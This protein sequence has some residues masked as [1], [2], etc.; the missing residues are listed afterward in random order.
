MFLNI[1]EFQFHEK[2]LLFK[3]KTWDVKYIKELFLIRIGF[4]FF[5]KH[6]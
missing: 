5:Q 3:L 2:Y 6:Q 4:A 1:L